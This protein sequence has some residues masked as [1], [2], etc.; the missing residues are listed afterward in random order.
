MHFAHVEDDFP[1]DAAHIRPNARATSVGSVAF[2][3][4]LQQ[5][6]DKDPP[7]E[8]LFIIRVKRKSGLQHAQNVQ[9]RIILRMRKIS[10]GPLFS[11][12]TFCNMH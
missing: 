8:T 12:H 7:R 2:L 4:Y 11:Y 9:I 1:L 5:Y 6:T 10:S 3:V